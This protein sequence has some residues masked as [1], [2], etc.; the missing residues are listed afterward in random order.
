M[1]NTVFGVSSPTDPTEVSTARE[2]AAIVN[3]VDFSAV[4]AD[5]VR[6]SEEERALGV[7]EAAATLDEVLPTVAEVSASI[8]QT[9]RQTTA[10]T[11]IPLESRFLYPSPNCTTPWADWD[12]WWKG[13]VRALEEEIGLHENLTEEAVGDSEDSGEGP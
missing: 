4:R 10:H 3:T 6:K 12:S 9:P 7:P 1:N 13:G 11:N 2:V 5:L 8:G